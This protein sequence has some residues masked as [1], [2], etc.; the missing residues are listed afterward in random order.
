MYISEFEA[1]PVYIVNSKIV[2]AMKR[3]CLKKKGRC[4]H[5]RLRAQTQPA[6]LI[7]F[8]LSGSMVPILFRGPGE[9][10]LD[11]GTGVRDGVQSS[12]QSALVHLALSPSSGRHTCTQN[13]QPTE[14]DQEG[15]QDPRGDT[16]SLGGVATQ[17]QC[18][19]MNLEEGAALPSSTLT[20]L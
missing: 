10:G 2:G 11:L 8:L 16:H 18:S 19:W 15:D 3:P 5:P 12:W 20:Y 7:Q 9:R 4:L 17:V 13:R 1:T 14:M 6:L